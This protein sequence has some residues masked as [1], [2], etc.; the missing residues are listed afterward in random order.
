V[1]IPG[2]SAGYPPR[3]ARSR[4]DDR[5]ALD[6]P[7]PQLF[8]GIRDVVER[9]PLHVR[10][11]S[12]GGRKCE[13]FGVL[14]ERPPVRGLHR[15]LVRHLEEVHGDG[16]ARD[17][18]DR[19]IGTG[20][21]HRGRLLQ[22]RVAP[23]DVEHNVGAAPVCCVAYRG[24]G[25]RVAQD[26]FIGAD[27]TRQ[28]ELLGVGVDRDDARAGARSDELHRQVAEPADADD[29][30][31]RTCVQLWC[32]PLDRVIGR[33]GRVAE[34][35]RDDRIEVAERDQRA[36]RRH[37]DVFGHAAIDAEAG[38]AAAEFAGVFAEVLGRQ[39]AGAARAA[40]PGT[41][42]RDRRAFRE[43]GDTSAE[44]GDPTGGFVPER[45][46]QIPRQ[47]PGRPLHEMQVGV[48]RARRGHLH[49]H[50]T[51]TGMRNVDI[52]E[53]GRLLPRHELERFHAATTV[54]SAWMTV[55]DEP[56]VHETGPNGLSDTEVAARVARGEVNIAAERSSRT[57]GEIV[58]ANV[59]T[60]FNA[61]LGGMLAVIIVVGPFQDALF[62]VVLVTN[63]LIGIVQE[64]RAKV[65]LDRLAVLNAPRARAVRDGTEREIAVTEVVRDDLLAIRAGDQL[66]ADGRV[67]IADGLEIDESLLTG[68]SDPVAKHEG[69]EVLSGSIVVAGSGR[70]Q[71]TRVGDDAYAAR[72]AKEARRFTLVRS[73]LMAGINDIL[74]YVTWAL[75]PTAALLALSQFHSH[76]GWREAMSG[77][78]AGVVA[79]V[80]E[81]L[82]LLTSLAFAVAAVTLARQKVLM[83][84]LPAVEGLARVDVVC[85]DKTGTL[86]EGS[87]R[88]DTFEP[89]DDGAPVA[90][91]LG[92]LGADEHGNATMG[93]IADA[94]DAPAEWTRTDAVPFSSARKWSAATFGDRG[95]WVIGAPEMVWVDAPAD[96][97]VRSRAEQLAAKGQR[98]L[99]L[100]TSGAALDGETLP[101]GLQPT[102][103][104]L[105]E[106]QVRDDAAD[107]LRY[108]GAQG[109]ALKV[110]SGDNPRTVGAVATRVGVPGA[111]HPYDARALPDAQ[112]ELAEVL[113]QQSVFGRVTPHQKREIVGA[114]QSRGHVV[115]MTGDGVND[116]L[117]LKDA[118]IGIAMGNG[119]P[120]TRAVAQ[121]VLLD[122]RFATMPGVVAEGRRVIANIERVA[123][124][125]VTK[126]VYA[127]LLA[128][129]VGIARWPYPF[130]PRHLTIVSSLTIGIPAF[131]IALQPNSR[132]YEPGFIRRV[133]RTTVPCGIVAA[134]ATFVAYAYVRNVDGETLTEARTAATVT[135]LIVGLGVLTL[136]ARPLNPYRTGVVLAMIALVFAGFSIPFAR[137]FYALDLPDGR[138]LG[139]T[140]LVGALALVVLEAGWTWVQHRLPA[141]ERTPRL[142]RT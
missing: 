37:E 129:A 11:D 123:N 47:G 72:L 137:D 50:L 6:L 93:A 63:A 52:H 75:V 83:Q 14:D 77:V 132:R 3:D 20:V 62:G 66:P 15:R 10:L 121:I 112:D 138:A 56:L 94:F 118:D 53:F 74:R 28:R 111:D 105:F 134:V 82:V 54:P 23:D 141:D 113:E 101:A 109:V 43:A 139:V 65:T 21:H 4:N 116:A 36:R 85:L 140:L 110:I 103:L 69:D 135:L 5:S 128:I 7:G 120:A 100:A 22:C 35:C 42:D 106:E 87:I 59:F 26:G 102:A 60:R 30:R 131:F 68:E 114:L 119:A 124:L 91:A 88:F 45:E 107:T 96:D 34:R 31:G 38:A 19:E 125:F 57:M 98:V 92:A 136:L 126:T 40:A 142:A 27:L 18:D 51:R 133:L 2:C 71:A 104:V 115:A 24:R 64:W 25:L 9:E 84:E 78:V 33:Q 130:L 99:L 67:H 61:I 48:A 86:T 46:R 76:H 97:P 29:D 58:R 79:M 117:A 122:G 17:T 1:G 55:T 16:T 95:T 89:L 32:G 108:F 44:F 80:P 81:G 70:F 73:E 39:A 49:E 8:V 41:V 90:D 12:T 13:H 127:M